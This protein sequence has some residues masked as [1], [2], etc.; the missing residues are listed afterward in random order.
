MDSN[1]D[2]HH[3]DYSIDDG[4]LIVEKIGEDTEDGNLIVQKIKD[5]KE[6]SLQE[7]TANHASPPTEPPASPPTPSAGDFELI[8]SK[9]TPLKPN[10]QHQY[11]LSGHTMSISSLK[12]RPNGSIL[13]SSGVFACLLQFA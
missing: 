8:V 10:Y 13:A 12:F 3:S 6:P 5:D 4:N 9:V 11:T 7:L 1:D 2:M